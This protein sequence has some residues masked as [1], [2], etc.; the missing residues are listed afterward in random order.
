METLTLNA[1]SKE[2]QKMIDLFRSG[3][4]FNG[5]MDEHGFEGDAVVVDMNMQISRNDNIVSHFYI[6]LVR[7]LLRFEDL[8][9]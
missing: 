9:L 5:T 4:V 2:H 8:E 1:K 6:A 7:E 3:E